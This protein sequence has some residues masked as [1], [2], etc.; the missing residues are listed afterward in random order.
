[1]TT[2]I[3]GLPE[4]LADLHRAV[5]FGVLNVTPDS[6]SDG[7]AHPDTEAAVAAGL[8]MASA[9]ADVID[10]G[11]ESTRP[12]AQR[13]TAERER[14][15]VLPVVEALAAEGLVVSVDTMRA[16]I[17]A[18]CVAAGA[19]MVNDVSGGLADPQMLSVIAAVDVPYI[20]MHWRGHGWHMDDKAVYTDVVEEVC[21][22]LRE[23]LHAC[24]DAGID[25]RR[26][27]L[28]PG[29]GFAKTPAHNWALLRSLDRLAAMGR[30]LLIGA[31][32]KR[33]LGA[34]LASGDE[35]RDIPGR[36]AATVALTALV[37]AQGAW[38]VRVHDVRDNADAVAVAAAWR[39]GT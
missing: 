36:G 25:R 29:I 10:V 8:A 2:Q 38:G 13:V 33:F 1:M 6:F 20:V 4:A 11:G 28:D 17:A 34:L 30:P 3:R 31:S 37:A 5:V 24:D 7:G 14:D 26:I 19:A 32:R 15:R 23:R 27:V 18:E 39:A 9:G 12:G 21:D 16:E 22:E 35:P